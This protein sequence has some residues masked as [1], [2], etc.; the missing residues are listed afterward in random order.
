MMNDE[1]ERLRQQVQEL[2]GRMVADSALLRVALLSTSTPQLRGTQGTVERL[3]D[4]TTVKLMLR[5]GPPG[6]LKAFED[7]RRQW[8]TVIAQELAAREAASPQN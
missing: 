1:V 2:A 7:Q 5:T 3:G 6:M 4:D 8:L